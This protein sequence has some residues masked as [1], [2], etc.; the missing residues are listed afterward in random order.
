MA[1]SVGRRKAQKTSVG[2]SSQTCKLTKRTVDHCT[3]PQSGQLFLRDTELKGFALRVT[4]GGAKSFIIERRINGRTRRITLARFP[5]LTVEQARIEAQKQL[6]AI[7]TGHDPVKERQQVRVQ[8]ITLHEAFKTFREAR[9]HLTIKTMYDYKR[10]MQVAFPDWQSKPLR[11][12]TKDMVLRRYQQLGRNRGP[13]YA[14]LAMR[15]LRSVL[16]FAMNHY[17]DADGNPILRDNPVLCLT[18]NR[19]WYPSKRRQTVIKAHQLPAWVDAV[20]RLRI[21]APIRVADTIA[22]YLLFLLFT[23]LRRSEA[24]RLQWADVDLQD[25]TLVIRHTKNREPLTLPLS[26]YLVEMLENRKATSTSDYV[27]PGE[28]QPGPLVEPRSGVFWVARISGVPFVLHDLRRTFITVAEGPDIPMYAIK[29]LV[30][31]KMNNDVTAGYIISDMERLRA[32]MQRIT[33]FLL[34]AS[35]KSKLNKVLPFRS[36]P[37]GA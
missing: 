8:S 4:A 26:D 32:P 36:I 33:D 27:F 24:V 34:S 18:R 6:G 23:G 7:V 3:A 13:H 28:G 25:R 5:V 15:S 37:T 20:N 10:V 16:N 1:R 31:H 9:S 19:A 30:N 35:N 12:I 14:T 21:E 22:D 11:E 17:D 2:S 29:R